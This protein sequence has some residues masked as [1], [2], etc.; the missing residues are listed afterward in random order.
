MAQNTVGASP[1]DQFWE[2][3]KLVG[4]TGSFDLRDYANCGMLSGKEERIALSDCR[5]P[6]PT[7]IT[8]RR[9]PEVV[10][11]LFSFRSELCYPDLLW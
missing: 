6:A 8:N 9:C 1:Q 2:N 7:G 10:V 5:E 3:G 11:S 4:K